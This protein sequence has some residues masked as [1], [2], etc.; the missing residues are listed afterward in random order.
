[1]KEETMSDTKQFIFG[2]GSFFES[3]SRI[4]TSPYRRRSGRRPSRI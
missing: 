4:M 3:R 1:M 2:Y